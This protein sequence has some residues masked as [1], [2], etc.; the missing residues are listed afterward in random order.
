M[1]HIL[2][3]A[4]FFCVIT[5]SYAQ[6]NTKT[7]NVILITLDGMRWQ[8]IFG[9]AEARLISKPFVSDSAAVIHEFWAET[10]QQRREKLM[11]FFWTTIAK[12]GQLYGNREFGNFVNVSNN[13]W[14]SYPGYSEILCG[15]AD[16]ARIN[17][18]DKFDNPNKNVLEFINSQKEFKN[19][20]AAYSSWDVFPY[21]IN[22]KRNGIPVNSGIIEAKASANEK[23][24]WLNDLMHQ[25]PNPL[26]DVRLDA[27]TFHYAFEYMK[28]N[29]PRVLYIAFDETDDF[30][31]GGKYDLYLDAAHYTDAFIKTLW[32]WCQSSEKYK[33]MT[34]ILITTDHGRGTDKKEDWKHHGE[35]MP[36]ADEIWMAVIG[37]DSPP[38]GEV[39]SNGQLYQNQVAKTMADLLGLNYTNDTP[40][41]AIISSVTSPASNAGGKKSK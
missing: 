10:P 13:Q 25:V 17:S 31:H 15:F 20:V 1:K 39:K 11:P 41:G 2:M 32:D 38:L 9:G 29:N 36:R 12:Q 22:T 5:I 30:A 28:K 23:E 14:F 19:K 21:I 35:K 26:G 7:E 33:D 40:P 18:N 16:N 4:F 24:K 27:F 37:P 6:K 34:T 3:V 8:E